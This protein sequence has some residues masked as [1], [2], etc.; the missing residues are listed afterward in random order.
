MTQQAPPNAEAVGGV[1]QGGTVDRARRRAGFGFP[2][3]P[4]AA[5]DLARSA[6]EALL[7]R[8]EDL[9]RHLAGVGGWRVRAIGTVDL[10][11]AHTREVIARTV[12]HTRD[13]RG[14]GKRRDKPAWRGR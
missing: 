7:G 10:L 12:K 9:M 3:R 13:N 1:R 11:P 8:A 6:D 4:R 2:D 5:E 14:L